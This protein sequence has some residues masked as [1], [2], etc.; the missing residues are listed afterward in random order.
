MAK[1]QKKVKPKEKHVAYIDR[2]WV[3]LIKRGL[4]RPESF[5]ENRRR[6][7]EAHGY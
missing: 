5:E 7:K 4:T 6:L 3:Q 1:K 2:K